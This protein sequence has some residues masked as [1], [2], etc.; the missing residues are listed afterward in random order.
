MKINLI[1]NLLICFFIYLYSPLKGD[2]F[3]DSALPTSINKTA[4]RSEVNNNTKSMYYQ[5]IN[6]SNID[7][8]EGAM[9]VV[10][11]D[12]EPIVKIRFYTNGNEKTDWLECKSK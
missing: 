8:I 1:K 10:D 4:N 12:F 2:I 7:S 11:S 5:S 6:I 3:S 9:I